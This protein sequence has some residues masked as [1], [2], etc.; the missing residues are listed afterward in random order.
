M[1]TASEII[2][3]IEEIPI[4]EAETE[5]LKLLGRIERLRILLDNRG[6]ALRTSKTITKCEKLVDNLW[7]ADIENRYGDDWLDVRQADAM[8]EK[9]IAYLRKP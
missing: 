3:W 5:E 7:D 8:I 1:L 6:I 4:E 9:A 2:E